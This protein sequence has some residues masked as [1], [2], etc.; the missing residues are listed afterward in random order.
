M[1]AAIWKP[2][3]GINPFSWYY[4]KYMSAIEIKSVGF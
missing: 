1:Y 2:A 4:L 3:H